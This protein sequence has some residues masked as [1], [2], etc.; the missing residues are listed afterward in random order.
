MSWHPTK[1]E[2]LIR[3]RFAETMQI[4]RF[5]PGGDRTQLTF[6]A[7]PVRGASYSPKDGDRFVF[8]KDTG[9]NEA[10]QLYRMMLRPAF[11]RA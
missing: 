10:D 4:H 1:R 3:T 2:M 7:D 8:S 11:R 5:G 9:G 6:F